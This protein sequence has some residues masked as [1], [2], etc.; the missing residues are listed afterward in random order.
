MMTLILL[1]GKAHILLMF[2]E[3]LKMNPIKYT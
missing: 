3:E 1:G 2:I